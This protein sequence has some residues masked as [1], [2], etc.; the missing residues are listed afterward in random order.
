MPRSASKTKQSIP[1]TEKVQAAW[2]LKATLVV[3]FVAAI[4]TYM[5]F[6]LLFFRGQ[7][8]IVLHPAKGTN[9]GSVPGNPVRF[10]PG[11]SGQP[12]LAG[13][14]MHGTPGTRYNNVTILFLSS[15]E[16]DRTGFLATQAALQSLGLNVFA[17][18]YRGYGQSSQVHPSQQR[19]QEDSEAAWD[20]LLHIR[21]I[22]ANSI[23]PFGVGVGA[24][25]AT[26]LAAAHP[27][28]PAVILSSPFTDLRE[29]VRHDQRWRFLPVGLLFRE[30]FPLTEPLSQLQKPKLLISIGQEDPQAYHSAAAPK[31]MVSLPASSG[32]L[33]NKAIT[34]FLDQYM[35]V[36]FPALN[37]KKSE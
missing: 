19:M 1:H 23:L 14:W 12:Q 2:L 20:Y 7:W 6:C 28:I 29:L 35:M 5:T 10:A 31:I 37:N 30:D 3:L 32:P 13:E 21:K 33:F 25:L 22:P 17:F 15:G 9:S 26:R 11:D 34:R 27:E 4:C 8:Q 18:D 24:S 36:A 16:G